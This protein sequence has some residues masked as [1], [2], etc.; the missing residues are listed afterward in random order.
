M[1]QPILDEN[2]SGSICFLKTCQKNSKR[3]WRHISS[4]L[5]FFCVLGRK[6]CE[7]P[8]GR[9]EKELSS[10]EVAQGRGCVCKGGGGGER[11]SL[12]RKEQSKMDLVQLGIFCKFP[13]LVSR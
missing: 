3:K 10:S 4:K 1:N 8:V 13:G 7:A 12:V 11:R 5:T 9:A 2:E 6:V